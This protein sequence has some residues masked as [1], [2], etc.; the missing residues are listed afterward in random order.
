MKRFVGKALLIALISMIGLGTLASC[1]NDVPKE[2]CNIGG[3]S[4]N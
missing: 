1:N 2:N 3:N 4:C